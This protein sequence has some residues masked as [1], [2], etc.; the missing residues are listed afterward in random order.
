MHL[1]TLICLIIAFQSEAM[2]M[3]FSLKNGYRLNWSGLLIFSAMP[4][5]YLLLTPLTQD[6]NWT[7]IKRSEA[8][9]DVLGTS[10][11]RLIF[12]PFAKGNLLINSPT[13]TWPKTRKLKLQFF[14]LISLNYNLNYNQIRIHC[15]YFLSYLTENY[16]WYKKAKISS[17]PSTAPF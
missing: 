7:Y 17:S 12:V 15:P 8:I 16:D 10:Y 2:I 5:K 4:E 11:I 13:S 1:K 14:T 6:A 3:P 9:L